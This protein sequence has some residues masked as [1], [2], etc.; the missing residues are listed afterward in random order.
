MSRQQ[1]LAADGDSRLPFE[2]V[3]RKPNK[4]SPVSKKPAKVSILL[5]GKLVIA[6]DAEAER[7]SREL[8]VRCT[9]TDVCRRWLEDAAAALESHKK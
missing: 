2:T 9:R 3:G 5:D 7:L 1:N 8:R 4:A 6:I